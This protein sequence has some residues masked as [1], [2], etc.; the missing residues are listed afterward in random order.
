MLGKG[1]WGGDETAPDYD[2]FATP[3][4]D[5]QAKLCDHGTE[6]AGSEEQLNE[7]E[8]FQNILYNSNPSP[9]RRTLSISQSRRSTP[10]LLDRIKFG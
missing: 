5:K 7:F 10:I 3:T 6:S 8:N 4:E 2:I 1:G 9:F